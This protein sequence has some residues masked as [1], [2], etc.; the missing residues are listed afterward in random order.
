MGLFG[1]RRRPWWAFL[2]IGGFCLWMGWSGIRESRSSASWSP[3]E[4]R[5]VSSKVSAQT[6]HRRGADGIEFKAEVIYEYV[7]DG[8][9]HTSSRVRWGGENFLSREDAEAFLQGYPMGKTVTVHYNPRKP[10]QAILEN[11]S[12]DTGV[13]YLVTGFG[14]VLVVL[15]LLKRGAEKF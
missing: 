1:R 5:V 15:G 8:V 7:A 3:A 9:R 12:E 2:L 4:G 14:V 11:G 6:I 10:D 13:L